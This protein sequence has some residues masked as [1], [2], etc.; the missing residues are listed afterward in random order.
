MKVQGSLVVITGAGSGMGRAMTL[1]LLRRGA[2]VAALDLRRE[3]LDE[4]KSLAT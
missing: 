4:T 1:E 2:K 3:S